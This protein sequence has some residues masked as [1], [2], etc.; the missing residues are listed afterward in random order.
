MA[1][2]VRGSNSLILRS[3]LNAGKARQLQIGDHKSGGIDF[4]RLQCSLGGFRLG[5]QVTQPLAHRDAQ[6]ADALFVIHNQE[7]QL[8]FICHGFPIVFS[9]ASINCC[10]RN[11]FSTQG[12]PA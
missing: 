12:V 5:A 4:E 2:S 3:K 10:T 6:P 7:A 11:G 1:T 8:Q 9:T